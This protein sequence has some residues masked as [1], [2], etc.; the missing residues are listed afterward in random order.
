MNVAHLHVLRIVGEMLHEA[1][2][3]ERIGKKSMKCSEGTIGDILLLFLEY[4]QFHFLN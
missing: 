4:Q 3:T 2:P 1:E